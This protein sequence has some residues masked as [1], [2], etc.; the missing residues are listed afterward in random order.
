[1]GNWQRTGNLMA[2]T[3]SQK[4]VASS[5]SK[6]FGSK[7][8]QIMRREMNRGKSTSAAHRIALRGK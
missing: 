8:A 7:H 4:E 1:M 6:R 2:L 3:K 5:H